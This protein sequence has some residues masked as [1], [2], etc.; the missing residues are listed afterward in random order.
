[1]ILSFTAALLVL[2]GQLPT[3]S[4]AARQATVQCTL[5]FW[6]CKDV[7]GDTVRVTLSDG[8]TGKTVTLADSVTLGEAPGRT[9]KFSVPDGY[10]SVVTFKAVNLGDAESEAD[11]N[12]KNGVTLGV[13]LAMNPSTHPP[14]RANFPAYTDQWTLTLDMR[15]DNPSESKESGGWKKSRKSQ[16]LDEARAR[17][18]A[19]E[20]KPHKTAAERK[21][22]EALE[23][24]I[25][26]AEIERDQR[27][28]DLEEEQAEYGG[29]AQPRGTVSPP[30]GPGA[31]DADPESV[32][33]Y[34]VTG[35]GTDSTASAGQTASL[36][37]LVGAPMR[38]IANS[39]SGMFADLKLA[40]QSGSD[41]SHFI[42]HDPTSSAVESAVMSA[43]A[44]GQD[45]RFWVH[46]KGARDTQLGL[47][48]YTK[49]LNA[50]VAAGDMTD[51]Q[52]A[53]ALAHVKV[54]TLGGADLKSVDWPPGV[55]VYAIRNPGDPIPKMFG[56]E[57]GFGTAVKAS[58][59][60]PRTA[61]NL[62]SSEHPLG[63]YTQNAK[64]GS[65]KIP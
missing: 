55:A 65:L 50:K 61:L 16:V 7:D 14:Y 34:L 17:A 58:Y 1:M 42:D 10:V 31:V 28:Q 25:M 4:A 22:L 52:R 37:E 64:P 3:P 59:D 33:N 30:F 9:L 18:A 29:K 44:D 51:Q 6:D 21:E 26:L 32:H 39:D 5:N 46:S 49:S 24:G 13:E 11:S 15:D 47:W 36:A 41:P 63:K 12:H 60:L 53:D 8:M 48:K 56:S 20:K 45:V 23:R 57:G 27:A 2:A 54:M 43:V 19:L 38:N 35:V 40:G 62:P